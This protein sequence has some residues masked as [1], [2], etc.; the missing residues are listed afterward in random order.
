M[1]LVKPFTNIILNQH[2]W[3]HFVFCMDMVLNT[4]M[5]RKIVSQNTS[6]TTWTREKIIGFVLGLKKL[7]SPCDHRQLNTGITNRA[8]YC[9]LFNSCSQQKHKLYLLF[10][11]Q[12]HEY[13]NA[14]YI[15]N[16]LLIQPDYARSPK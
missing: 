13:M 6:V 12:R 2:I 11:N 1:F 15:V 5:N 7:Y 16:Q 3:M 14:R 4:A 9:F 10:L 8:V